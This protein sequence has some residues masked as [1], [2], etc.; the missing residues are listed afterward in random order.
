MVRRIQALRKE[1]DFDIDDRIVVYYAGSSEVEDVFNDE[2]EYIMAET[3]SDDLVNGVAPS[4]A[5]VQDY[6]IDGLRVKLG[7]IR[8]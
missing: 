3:L 5:K 6:E 4:E 8:K 2:A 1:A 7:V